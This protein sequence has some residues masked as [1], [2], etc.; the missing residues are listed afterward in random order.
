MKSFLK[1]VSLCV[2]GAVVFAVVLGISGL[3]TNVG[4]WFG[5]LL[6]VLVAAAMLKGIVPEKYSGAAIAFL[7]TLPLVMVGGSLLWSSVLYPMAPRLWDSMSERRTDVEIQS[8]E[9]VGTS[10]TEGRAAL[11][12]SYQ[13]AKQTL[14]ADFHKELANIETYRVSGQ[15]TH[16]ECNRLIQLRKEWYKTSSAECAKSYG[17]YDEDDGG[18]FA[19]W[20]WPDWTKGNSK[21]AIGLLGV[22]MVIFVIVFLLVKSDHK[23]MAALF[24]VGVV[25]FLFQA[26][27]GA[28]V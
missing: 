1:Q 13:T 19:N 6:F 28:I 12:G 4:K 18:W 14:A 11:F 25:I 8:A 23:V 27:L 9:M 21:I 2:V 10:D 16:A 3:A 22:F 17:Y 7:V 26:V 20:H 15:L 5:L 24:L